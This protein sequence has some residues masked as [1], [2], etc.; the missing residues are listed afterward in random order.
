MALPQLVEFSGVEFQ[1]LVSL[2]ALRVEK[3]CRSLNTGRSLLD[4]IYLSL[5]TGAQALQDFVFC[6]HNGSRLELECVYAQVMLW[7]VCRHKSIIR[8]IG[9]CAIIVANKLDENLFKQWGV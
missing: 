5:P 1:G 2:V 8:T 9:D 7:F 6:S 3:F 4:E